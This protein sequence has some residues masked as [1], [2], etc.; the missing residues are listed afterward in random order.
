MKNVL[1]IGP[2]RQQDSWGED[3]RDY[4]RALSTNPEISLSIRPI[5]YTNFLAPNI[6]EQIV[7]YEHTIHNSYDIILQYALSSSFHIG[8]KA[9]KN[10][11][12]VSAEFHNGKS[13]YNSLILNKLSEI[14]VSTEYEKKALLSMDVTKPIKVIPKP[15]NLKD[16]SLNKENNI[17]FPSIIDSTFKF[18][19]RSPHNE[20]SNLQ[21]LITAFHLAFSETDRVSLVLAPNADSVNTPQITRSSI[22]K[23]AQQIKND[24]H[25]NKI[26]KNEIII[27]DYFDSNMILNIHN[28]CDCFIN[29]GNGSHFDK[30]TLIALYLGKTPI[31]PQNTGLESLVSGESGGFVVKTI[32]NPILLNKP[33][34]PDEYDLFNANYSWKSPTISSLIEVLQKAYHMHKNDRKN[35]Q[36]KQ[37]FGSTQINQYSY[38][39]IG[40]QLCS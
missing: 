33:P 29:I 1:F 9:A 20:R 37:S 21:L 10:I 11:G 12:I 15:I 39:N 30:E 16:I 35:Y 3:A 6:D 38:E 13:V 40:Q 4:I 17:K 23:L 25:T 5:Y 27:A 2:Y 14:Y 31:V 7:K 36:A 32:T 8:Q 18:Y 28:S 24:L 34:L 22:E 19:C 26:F